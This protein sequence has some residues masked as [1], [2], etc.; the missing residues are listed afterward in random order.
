MFY[1]TKIRALFLIQHVC[2]QVFNE[3]PCFID[4]SQ[5]NTLLYCILITILSGN[6]CRKTC[7]F[8]CFSPKISFSL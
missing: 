4:L 7:F 5:K 2:W 3:K 6:A 1:N 8:A